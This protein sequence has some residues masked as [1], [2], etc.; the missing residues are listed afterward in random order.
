[1]YI[2]SVTIIVQL[3]CSDFFL[4]MG[5]ETYKEACTRRRLN[6]AVNGASDYVELLPGINKA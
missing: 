3:L 6:Q 2:F 5:G 4:R 1:M